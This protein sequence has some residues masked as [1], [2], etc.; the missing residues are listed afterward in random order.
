MVRSQTNIDIE[1]AKRGIRTDSEL[2][3]ALGFSQQQLSYRIN[4]KISMD[5]LERLASFFE[6]TVKKLLKD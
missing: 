1:M 4:G 6:T 2:A 3:T 5:T